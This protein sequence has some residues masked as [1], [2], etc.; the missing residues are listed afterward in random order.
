MGRAEVIFGLLI[1]VPIAVL[2][3]LLAGPS[4]RRWRRRRIR[5][6]EPPADLE[7]VLARNVSFYRRLP[8]ELKTQ[9]NGHVNVF[10]A[11]KTFIGA[12]GQE[13]TN[14]IRY[15]VAGTACLLL[16][17]REPEYFP[18]FRSILIY[19]DTYETTE[20]RYDGTVETHQRSRRA[21]ESW[22]RG[23]IVLSWGDVVRGVTNPA[24][25]FNVVLHEFA[26]KLDEQ[27][28]GTDG[29][30][31]LHEAEHFDEW[32]EVLTREYEALRKRVA[33]RKNRVLDAYGLTSPPEFF[34]V[35]T[36]SFFE[37]S[38]MMQ[39]R[40]PDLYEQLQRFYRVD[41]AEWPGD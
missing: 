19:P 7:A 2:V 29:L 10:L 30:P 17:N 26:H 11:E 24:D 1:A 35:A 22:H 18:G 16:L 9:L 14:E 32:V 15:I 27:H 5:A 37:K 39:K 20:V 34:A 41:P 38:R 40:L 13:I 4:V 21:G 23:P 36:E 12:G 33:R 25:G 31:D 8:P 3:Y 6:A 28:G